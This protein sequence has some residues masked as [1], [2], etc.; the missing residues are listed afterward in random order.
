[1]DGAALGADT[2]TPQE[3]QRLIHGLDRT[4]DADVW[5]ELHKRGDMTDFFDAVEIVAGLR[6]EW[7]IRREV[8]AGG[9]HLRPLHD[10]WLEDSEDWWYFPEES[11]WFNSHLDAEEA[12]ERHGLEGY[13]LV[14][15][16]VGPVEV[17]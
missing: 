7:A 10:Y 6:T 5:G 8:Y 12:A 13:Q 11:A 4:N 15:R 1:M 2:V 9:K 17:V 14:T 16:L 3:A